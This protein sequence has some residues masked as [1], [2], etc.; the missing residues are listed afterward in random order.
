[1]IRHPYSSNLKN[2]LISSENEW[3]NDRMDGLKTHI[4]FDEDHIAAK[5][6]MVSAIATRRLHRPRVNREP[7]ATQTDDALKIRF[8]TDRDMNA[9]R[10]TSTL[11]R[12][13]EKT[14][15]ESKLRKPE[16]VNRPRQFGRIDDTHT[17][18]NFATADL[19]EDARGVD[20]KTMN[21]EKD[22]RYIPLTERPLQLRNVDGL[23]YSSV[24]FYNNPLSPT[25]FV[26]DEPFTR[27]G[28]NT[29]RVD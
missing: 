23:D 6:S 8:L 1:M 2:K 4:G 11:G 24:K 25:D 15:I 26:S 14:N 22:L 10:T 9:Y 27:G 21:D 19:P 17:L 29:R 13:P 20:V 16:R 3:R 12:P 7:L 28:I 18:V 5:D